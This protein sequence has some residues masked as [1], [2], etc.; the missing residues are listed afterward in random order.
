MFACFALSASFS[1]SFV[2]FSNRVIN[3]SIGFRAVCVS[4][5]LVQLPDTDPLSNSEVTAAMA[6]DP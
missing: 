1:G 6:G 3:F 5:T 2:A 4:H